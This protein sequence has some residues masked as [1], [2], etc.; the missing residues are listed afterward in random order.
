[1]EQVAHHYAQVVMAGYDVSHDMQHIARVLANAEVV[2]D[3]LSN[4]AVEFDARA[5]RIGALLH[6]VADHKYAGSDAR[7]RVQNCM[8]YLMVTTPPG[9]P[10][11]GDD[12]ALAKIRAIIERTSYTTHLKERQMNPIPY[13]PP[14]VAIARDADML[15]AMG[16]IGNLRAFAVSAIRKTPAAHATT[17]TV[18]EWRAAGCKVLEEDGSLAGHYYAKLLHLPSLMFTDK[19]KQM[20]LELLPTMYDQVDR[21]VLCARKLAQ[22]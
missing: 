6:D 4:E 8:E 13:T 15:D 10:L 19:A 3:S 12:V 9:D 21:M 5:V 1:M 2:M 11:L 17:P 20:A 18:D 22:Q 7:Q 16:T 14:E